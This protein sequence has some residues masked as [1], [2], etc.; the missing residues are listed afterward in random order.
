MIAGD[1]AFVDGDGLLENLFEFLSLGF[2]VEVDMKLF[3]AFFE[4]WLSGRTV[5]AN[6]R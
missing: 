3:K 2:A 4:C 5:L 6:L 1:L